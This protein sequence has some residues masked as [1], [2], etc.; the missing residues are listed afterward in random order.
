MI[1][2]ITTAFGR[3]TNK[4]GSRVL[5]ISTQRTLAG[6]HGSLSA[7]ELRLLVAGMVD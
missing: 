5:P 7:Q 4:T 6:T 1:K 3:P 2:T